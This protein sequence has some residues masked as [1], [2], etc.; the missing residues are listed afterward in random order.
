MM[1]ADPHVSGCLTASTRI[2]RA[3][4]GAEITCGE[5]VE[6]GERP[7]VWSLDA[8]LRMAARP[9]TNVFA[10]GRQ[11]VFTFRL[12]SAR[13]LEATADQSFMTLT[14]WTPLSELTAGDRVGLPRRV[15]EPLHSQ[16]RTYAEVVLLAHMIG[17]GSCVKNQPIRYASID[18]QNLR[19]VTNAAK[20]FGVTAV[21][22]EYPAA[23]VTTL[24]LPAPYRLARGK[25]NPVAAGLDGL[26]LFGK[27]SYEKFVPAELFAAPNDQVAL[28]LRHL[29][30]TD[31]CVTW[32][33]RQGLANVYYASTSR[34][35]DDVRQLLL[36]LNISSRLYRTP[37]SG[38]RDSWHLRVFGVNNQRR[39][40]Q[41][42][43]VH[44]EKFF[45]GREVLFKL[46]GVKGNENV[47]TV[48]REV[49]DQV[50]HTLTERQMTHRAFA[51]AIN[52]KFCG[53]TM[54]K[55]SPSRGRLHRAA[56]ILNDR[57]LHDLT[58]NDVLWDKIVEITSIG[59]HDVYQVS[60]ADTHNLVAQGISVHSS[61]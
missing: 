56:A 14:G 27:R 45:A 61:L 52:T 25:R 18:E 51:Q 50:R 21:R 13:Q 8:D 54:W 46:R 22:D 11:E 55:H 28:F 58:N 17:D 48:P 26:G 32:D 29:W 38:Y 2:L 59:E 19:A 37:K 5:L 15:P 42:V 3:E 49:W 57:N 23:R 36:R 34:R 7:L 9:L 10:V 24:R 31:G 12:A 6:T 16:R 20:H 47:D 43:D 1:T 30:A 41:T 44:G 53:S 40:L 39:F 33:G 35:L 60:V 4:N